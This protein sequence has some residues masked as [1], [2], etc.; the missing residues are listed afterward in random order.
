M[1]GDL[2]GALLASSVVIM[3]ITSL[4]IAMRLW[5][6]ANLKTTGVDDCT[7]DPPELGVRKDEVLTMPKQT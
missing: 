3:C 7:N 2:S 4:A 6:R 1:A 5:I